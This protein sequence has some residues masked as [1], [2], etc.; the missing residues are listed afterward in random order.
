MGIKL[1]VLDM[2][3]TTVHDE[4]FVNVALQNA[5]M[6]QNVDCSRDDI[7]SVMGMAK[8]L[9]IKLLLEMRAKDK[10]SITNE[11]V[12]EIHTSFQNKMVDFYDNSQ[13][14][15]EI[16]GVSEAFRQFNKMNI[17]VAIDTGFDRRI[18]NA[19]FQRVGWIENGLV[20]YTVTSDEVENGRPHPDMVFKA[21]KHF[22]ISDAKEVVKVG[23]TPSD[24]NEGNNAGCGLNIAVLS[25]ACTKEELI[26]CPHSH[27]LDSVAQI[28]ELLKG[29][30][31]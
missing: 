2:A 31:L 21:M 7:N 11:L 25:G 22:D 6:E 23:D 8:P 1:V 29:L 30:L 14:I 10:E 17:K 26:I 27:I 12:S 4:D 24:L 15:K 3:G 19:I 28:P 18:A 5:L 13:T 9:A 16:E 20:D